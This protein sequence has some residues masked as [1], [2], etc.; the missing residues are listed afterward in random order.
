[1]KSNFAMNVA[2]I[3]LVTQRPSLTKAAAMLISTATTFSLMANA[4]FFE[5]F[6]SSRLLLVLVS[7]LA[8]YV[9]LCPRLLLFREFALYAVFVLYMVCALLWTP[10]FV[11]ALNTL[12]PAVNFLLILLLFG[13]L[14]TF[15]DPRVV[16]LGLVAGFI[17]GAATY[18][19]ASGFPLRV[20][21]EFSYNGVAAMYLFGLF[22]VL[23]F[24]W[25]YRSSVLAS[26]MAV[27][28]IFHVVATTSIKTN[29]GIA[30]GAG[31]AAIVYF[32]LTGRLLRRNAVYLLIAIGVVAYEI[33][34]ND[35]VMEQF[36][37][38]FAR[39]SI[40]VELLQ[41]REAQDGYGGFNE[42]RLWM[43]D[44]LSAWLYN[45]MF[46]YGVEAFRSTHDATSHSTVIDL[47]Y[48]TGLIGFALFYCTFAS[49][50]W[51]LARADP[52][53][54]EGL[55][56]I[57]LGGAICYVFVSLSGLSYY[58]T[59]LAVFIA[60]AAGLLRRPPASSRGE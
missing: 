21:D 39:V 26:A 31:V 32:R 25:A 55:K 38:A 48:N 24:G 49:L 29:L 34:S 8:A 14:I 18:T 6:T 45:P 4:A 11:L 3:V 57:F 19:V 58:Q 54:D 47:L 40:G 56:G 44:G 20:P 27:I 43:E 36:K 9:L 17:A 16:I 37:Y 42:R 53:I 60:I 59:F 23:T 30:L 1:M 12:F 7:L 5:A 41:T 52:S 2:D 50:V 15:S 33:V 10:D 35:A 46:G 51:R 28:I 22:A 13:S